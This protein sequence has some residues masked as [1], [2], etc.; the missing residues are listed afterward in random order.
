MN[1]I[2]SCMGNFFRAVL[3]DFT[4]NYRTKITLGGKCRDS[5]NYRGY[6]A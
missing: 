6:F 1:G 2:L 4:K 3:G 5:V